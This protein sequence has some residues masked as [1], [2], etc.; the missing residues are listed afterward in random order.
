MEET[1]PRRLIVRTV[2]KSR[3]CMHLFFVCFVVVLVVVFSSFYLFGFFS[4]LFFWFC[5]CFVYFI[6]LFCFVC[7]GSSP[8][9]STCVCSRNLSALAILL[10][11]VWKALHV[12][13]RYPFHLRVTA[14]ARTDPGHSAQSAGGR[15]Q[16]NIRSLI[17]FGGSDT[18][19]WCMVV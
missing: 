9:R 14:V 16:L 11:L 2:P 19:N 7:F 3:E 10:V 5:C 6:C 15:L 12:L 17:G 18:V 8:E 13:F 1:N 4:V